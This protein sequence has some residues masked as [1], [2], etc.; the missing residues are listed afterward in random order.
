MSI[1]LL[2]VYDR[3]LAD[4]DAPTD[5]PM[6]FHVDPFGDTIFNRGQVGAL[7]AEIDVLRSREPVEERWRALDELTY[8]CHL[9]RQRP[10]R[11]LW[12][13]GD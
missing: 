12:F 10:H 11:Y 1:S 2:D 4:D 7:L 8:L 13:I 6:L 9:S 3:L 5:F